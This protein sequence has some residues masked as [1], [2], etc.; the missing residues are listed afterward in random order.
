[1]KFIDLLTEGINDKFL[2]KA[3][4]LAGGPGSGK[5]F[6]NKQMFGGI[7]AKVI[8]SDDIFERK[9][10]SNNIPLTIDDKKVEQYK[11]QMELRGQAKKLTQEKQNLFINGMLPIIIDGTGR[12]YDKIKNKQQALSQ[13]GYDTGLVFVNTSL[14]V[15]KERNL[16]RA[17][18]VPDNIITNAWNAVQQNIGKFQSLFKNSFTVIDNND[19]LDKKGI[20]KLGIALH[21]KALKFFNTPVQNARGQATLELLR[22]LK[23][24]T[25]SDLP[26]GIIE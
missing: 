15:A 9:L 11:K 13:M 1:M 22:K 19:V 20:D 2:F 10:K 14:D 25:L 4:F 17:R 12:E 26:D 6:I 24:K 8:N 16:K 23:G 5:S 18:T 21:R 3:I 7:Q